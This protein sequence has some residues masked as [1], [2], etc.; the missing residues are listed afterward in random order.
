MGSEAPVCFL[1]SFDNAVALD[2]AMAGTNTVLHLFHRRSRPTTKCASTASAKKCRP[3]ASCPNGPH[4][5]QDCHDAG[6]IY[7]I[8]GSWPPVAFRH[9]APH[10]SHKT[11]GELLDGV[12][13]LDPV[14]IRDINNPHSQ[15]A[16]SPS[17]AATWPPMA[18]SSKAPGCCR[19]CSHSKAVRSA[20]TA[21][22]GLRRHPRRQ[23][24]GRRHGGIRYEGPKG[25]PG[26]QEMLAPTSYIKGAGLS[27]KVAW[28]PTV[29]FRRHLR[30]QHR[31]R[32]ARGRRRWPMAWWKRRPHR[33]R[34]AERRIE[35]LVDEETRPSAES[36]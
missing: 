8:L 13:S 24:Q 1:E 2:I 23:G 22:P 3:S 28:S 32:F 16:A 14:V 33:L 4:H 34:H 6:G 5:I 36:W 27:G 9:L 35:L 26:M 21:K 7:A 17:S 18:A 15:T 25:G 20:L 12:R 19:K 10:L 11:F 30:R 29:V 31:P